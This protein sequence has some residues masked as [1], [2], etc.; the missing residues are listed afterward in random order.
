M[1]R[2]ALRRRHG[3]DT[4]SVATLL[5]INKSTADVRHFTFPSA[6]TRRERTEN[7]GPIISL[8]IFARLPSRPVYFTRTIRSDGKSV[9]NN[10]AT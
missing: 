10:L 6:D 2:G 4:P 8:K 1:I 7:S 3:A 5:S 9:D